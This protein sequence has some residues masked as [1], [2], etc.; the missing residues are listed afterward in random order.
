MAWPE[1]LATPLGHPGP[2]LCFVP[3]EVSC[4]WGPR[5]ACRWTHMYVC[6]SG[7]R[8]GS[9]GLALT[10]RAEGLCHE[11]TSPKMQ[12]GQRVPGSYHLR[13]DSSP[14]PMIFMCMSISSMGHLSHVPQTRVAR[15]CLYGTM[16]CKATGQLKPQPGGPRGQSRRSRAQGRQDEDP[17][18][19]EV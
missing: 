9:R 17:H 14:L 10:T 6:A 19:A 18:N 3:P 13:Q 1:D 5:G 11:P 12:K 4:R 15:P 2:S 7:E 8:E 16:G